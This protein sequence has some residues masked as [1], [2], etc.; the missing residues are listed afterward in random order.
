MGLLPPPDRSPD[1]SPDVAAA[2]K[3]P[4]TPPPPPP[5]K[6]KSFLPPAEQKLE[7]PSFAL[8]RMIDRPKA[9][10]TA[11]AAPIKPAPAVAPPGRQ[12]PPPAAME[13]PKL[14]LPGLGVPVLPRTG[15]PGPP[16]PASASASPPPEAGAEK[17]EKKKDNYVFTEAALKEFIAKDRPQRREEERGARGGRDSEIRRAAAAPGEKK[18]PESVPPVKGQPTISL[19]GLGGGLAPE[20]TLVA[21]AAATG[22][23]LPAEKKKKA[24]KIAA[25]RRRIAEETAAARKKADETASERKRIADATAASKKAADEAAAAKR[26]AQAKLLREAEEKRRIAADGKFVRC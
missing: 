22:T 8:P 18:T 17:E 10:T 16:K 15:I 12:P 1:A 14:S 23:A 9:A 24:D 5:V 2:A 6:Q 4:A 26:E 20:A 25:E 11:A 13:V 7:L 3:K 21:G 19:F